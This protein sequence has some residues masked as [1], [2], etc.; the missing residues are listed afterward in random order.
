MVGSIIVVVLFLVFDYVGTV[1]THRPIAE[2]CRLKN[3]IH[4]TSDIGTKQ[5]LRNE[6]KK[7]TFIQAVGITL[8]FLSAFLKII[9]ILL[10]GS[11]NLMFYVIMAL[12]YIIV[13]Y[14]HIFH[15]GY[16]FAE[17]RT[18]KMFKKQHAKWANSKM[19]A[20]TGQIEEE[21]I[22]YK[23]QELKTPF[24]SDIELNIKKGTPI[25]IGK[26]SIELTD[27]DEK[28]NKPFYHYSLKTTGILLDDDIKL[29]INGQSPEQAGIIALECRKHQVNRI[30]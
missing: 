16:F 29:L 26:H 22:P 24:I 28:N 17:L 18:E 3:I 20:A 7:G 5:G 19:L 21:N 30:H 10:L 15:T 11:F 25:S 4:F 27:I 13:I 9:A 12:L 8:I 6:L 1:F 23:A 2:R 14:I